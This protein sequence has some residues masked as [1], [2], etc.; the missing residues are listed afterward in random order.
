M[1]MCRRICRDLWPQIE[2]EENPMTYI[3]NGVHVPTFLAQEWSDLF[4]RYLGYEW[5]NKM[6]D[7]DFWLR[8][9]TI[10]IICSGASDRP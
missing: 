3:T 10:P 9:D 8:I 5:R 6:C 2:P 7:K 1:A 4:D